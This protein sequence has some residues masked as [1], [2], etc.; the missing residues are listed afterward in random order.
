VRVPEV[1]RRARFAP[2]PLDGV[3]VARHLGPQDLDRDVVA[4][5]EVARA[6]DRAH[7]AAPE[8]LLDRV[9]A[10]EDAADERVPALDRPQRHAVVRTEDPPVVELFVADGAAFHLG[11]PWSVV[12]RCHPKPRVNVLSRRAEA[13]DHGTRATD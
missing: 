13:T 9:L 4:D 8:A 10:V 5:E 7:P 12:S 3:L 11:G 1:A 2:Q 6:V